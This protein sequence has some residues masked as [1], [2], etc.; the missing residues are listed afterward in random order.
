MTTSIVRPTS[1]FEEL[2]D[3]RL[4]T[5]LRRQLRLLDRGQTDH[6]TIPIV[7]V[8]DAG[9][10]VI[11]VEE[12]RE[13]FILA[14][15]EA[16]AGSLARDSLEGLLAMKRFADM[17]SNMPC[18][19]LGADM[20]SATLPI[21]RALSILCRSFELSI[22]QYIVLV[23]VGNRGHDSMELLERFRAVRGDVQG[24]EEVQ[25]LLD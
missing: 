1:P 3:P 24:V 21:G 19:P 4:C 22:P 6:P 23:S 15:D 20:E 2:L 16:I 17:L 13:M 10:T 14:R 12:E 7:W 9:Y 11:D 18:R 5:S 25:H 8:E